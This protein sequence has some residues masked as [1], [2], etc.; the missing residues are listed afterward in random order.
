M[1]KKIQIIFVIVAL[2]V[3]FTISF[4]IALWTDIPHVQWHNG[5]HIRIEIHD[6]ESTIITDVQS[7]ISGTN[8]VWDQSA[9]EVWHDAG[10]VRIIVLGES[11]RT[12]LQ[13]WVLDNII[14]WNENFHDVWKDA[15]DIRVV[16]DLDGD[17]VD[18]DIYLQEYINAEI[19]ALA[20]IIRSGDLITLRHD[21]RSKYVSVSTTSNRRLNANRDNVQFTIEQFTINKVGGN[22]G[23]KILSGDEIELIS[24]LTEKTV[25]YEDL[26]LGLDG[27]HAKASGIEFTSLIIEKQDGTTSEQL[28]CGDDQITLLGLGDGGDQTEGIG[29]FTAAECGLGLCSEHQ[30]ER[31]L[32]DPL[33]DDGSLVFFTIYD[34]NGNCVDNGT[35][36]P[37]TASGETCITMVRS[38]H[39]DW[40]RIPITVACLDKPL[41]VYSLVQIKD[42]WTSLELM[43]ACSTSAG[44]TCAA[45]LAEIRTSWS[46]PSLGNACENADSNCIVENARANPSWTVNRLNDECINEFA[47]T[48][49]GKTDKIYAQDWEGSG[50]D[51]GVIWDRNGLQLANQGQIS[52]DYVDWVASYDIPV[53]AG[54]RIEH[55]LSGTGG[56]VTVHLLDRSSVQYDSILFNVN[57]IVYDIPQEGFVRFPIGTRANEYNALYV[58]ECLNY[59][60]V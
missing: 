47:C 33:E 34:E 2:I 24:S 27:V 38:L 39:P 58:Y 57:N 37:L 50:D 54:E 45:D 46:S 10:D 32:Y 48:E 13:S 49:F 30:L 21:K 11:T 43:L 44:T 22:D 16:Y 18:D 51:R 20:E 7:W 53:E 23:D 42:T 29:Y 4:T 14:V 55:R 5:E 26:L 52:N 17:L 60:I 41:C 19:Q 15:E 28:E 6:G 9:H 8:T 1:A 12:D 56:Y 40:G 35:V 3:L 36:E 31:G 59:G 25:K